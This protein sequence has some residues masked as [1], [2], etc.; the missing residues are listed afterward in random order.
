M[1][2]LET[3]GIIP[4]MATQSWVKGLP[5]QDLFV[6][7][8]DYGWIRAFSGHGWVPNDVVLVG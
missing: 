6:R 7:R 1:K 2:D 8:R 3:D 5:N 4:A